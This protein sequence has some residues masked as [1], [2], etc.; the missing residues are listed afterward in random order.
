M[1][2]DNET[3]ENGIKESKDQYS[4]INRLKDEQIKSQNEESKRR[5]KCLL[6]NA[7]IE[8]RKEGLEKE[9][10]EMEANNKTLEEKLHKLLRKNNL[11]QMERDNNDA[12][13][14]KMKVDLQLQ[15]NEFEKW[16]KSVDEDKKEIE[17]KMR[18]R[19]L[20]N[21]DVVQAEEK[22]RD[23]VSAKQTLENE[24]KKLQNKI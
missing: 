15:T 6:E 19:D 12:L 4:K 7:N 17:A 14:E 22:E 1:K 5:E 16:K 9:V 18:E 24:L 23:K 11:Q 8:A 20:L 3:I 21:K 10:A 2:S 13:K